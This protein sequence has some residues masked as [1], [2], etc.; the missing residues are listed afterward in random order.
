GR[1]RGGPRGPPRPPRHE[2]AGGRRLVGIDVR[3]AARRREREPAVIAAASA[4]AASPYPPFTASRSA[5]DAL[6]DGTVDCDTVGG[7][8]TP[9]SRFGPR[10][11]LPGRLPEAT[12][13]AGNRPV[14]H[15]ASQLRDQSAS[16]GVGRPAVIAGSAFA[17]C[18]LGVIAAMPP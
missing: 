1:P 6:N 4:T 3:E 15:Q 12:E 9:D 7:A 5:L 8:A 13:K 14:P 10:V 18:K 2:G 11:A 17:Y 16:F